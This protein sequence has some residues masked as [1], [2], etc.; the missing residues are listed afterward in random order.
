MPAGKHQ[1]T[2]KGEASKSRRCEFEPGTFP[3]T[4]FSYDGRW[5]WV[6]HHADTPP[7]NT[8]GSI[9]AAAPRKQV[10]LPRDAPP[11]PGGVIQKLIPAIRTWRKQQQPPLA[12]PE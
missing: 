2:S 3:E 10:L 11:G 6:H 5:G 1:A 7:H 8:D 12:P 9:V 4:E